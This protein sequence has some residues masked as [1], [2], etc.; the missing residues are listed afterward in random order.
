MKNKKILK[1]HQK[2]KFKIKIQIFNNIQILIKKKKQ[3]NRNYLL[4]IKF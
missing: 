2:A 4:K 1:N 3:Y